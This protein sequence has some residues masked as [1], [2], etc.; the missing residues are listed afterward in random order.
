MLFLQVNCSL[1]HPYLVINSESIM[2][3]ASRFIWRLFVAGIGFLIILIVAINLGLMGK[4]PSLKE[5][6]NP[7]SSIASEVFA[8]DGTLLGK[9]YILNRSNSKYA[10]I[11][12]NV[13]N[14]LIATEDE[15]FF[16]HSGIDGKAVMRAVFLL[17]SKGGGS[18]ITQ[19]LA[20]NLFPRQN[21]S[22]LTLPIIKLKE[23]IMAIKLEK[24][25]TKQEIIT[26][27]LNTVPFGDNTY[28]IKNASLTFFSKQ[29]GDLSIDEAAVLV[30][31]LKGNT[32][33]NPRRNPE[34]ATDRRNTVMEQMV[35]YNYLSADKAVALKQKPIKLKYRK[36]DNHQGLAP[37]FRQVVE[38]EVK[39]WCKQHEKQNGDQYDIYKDGL[40]IYTTIDP[41][42]QRYA[43]EAVAMHMKDLQV[44]FAAQ[45]KIKNGTVWKSGKPKQTLEQLVQR[46]DRYLV[47]KENGLSETEIMKAF[48]TPVK[49][50]VFSWKAKDHM[51]DTTM[52]PMDSLKYM[53]A[54][55]QAGFMAMD[56]ITGEVKAWVGGIDH[57]FF[58]YDHVNIGTKR[59]VGSTIKPLLYTLAVDNGYSPCSAVSTAPQH[60]AG[61]KSAYNAGGSKYGSMAMKTALAL[62]VNN[63]SLYLLN[64]VGIG[65]FI[66]FAHKCGITS[67]IESVPSI[68]LGVSDIS[69][70]EM[71][72]AYTMFPNRGINTKPIFIG[73]IEDKN[74]NLLQNFVPVQKEIINEH[75]A[76]KMVNMMKG[77]TEIGTAKRLRY[78][79][80]LQG[81]MAGKTGTTNNQADAWFIGYTPQLLAGAWVGCD[82][83]FLRFSSTAQGQGAAAALPIWAYFFKKVMNDS[84]TGISSTAQF[85]APEGFSNCGD[86][87]D[88]AGQYYPEYDD[89]NTSPTDS[90]NLQ[91][92]TAEPMEEVP[93]TEW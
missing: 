74:G 47:M 85:I 21:A 62:S 8:A 65:S 89:E 43:E 75:T 91:I 58:Q 5:L 76:F 3:R 35:K 88:V 46:S 56:P 45:P 66:D 25:L 82:D 54:I 40:K 44:A 33:Y 27:Y 63:A 16:E 15:R 11:S 81:E 24:N 10:E 90:N 61:Q 38:Q 79:Y 19:Q 64:Q 49:L 87:G 92:D 84:K 71:L 12:P 29:P 59:Q 14:A 55:L 51:V 50:K 53:R 6:E 48:N 86:L 26:L 80:G 52:T 31:M 42:M 93:V 22:F 2:S 68:A 18:T 77:V 20:K 57:N 41:R 78:R 39:K 30:G 69:L 34:R 37:Y 17:G 9:Y 67:N 73:K 23:W 32:L 83:R 60:F 36:L 28:G 70:Y 7:S 72:W 13:F 4:M 1:C